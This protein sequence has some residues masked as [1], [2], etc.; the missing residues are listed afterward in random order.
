MSRAL[1]ALPLVLAALAAGC[2]G[3]PSSTSEFE[4]EEQNV[5]DTVEKLQTAGETGD[6]KTICD[7]L[8]ASALREQVQAAGSTCEQELDKAIKDADDF[9]LEVQDVA[10]TGDTATA[11][12]EGRD[13]GAE[14][15]R[16]FEFVREGTDWRATAVG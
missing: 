2:A 9:D 11:R 13:R 12:V 14:R 8:L 1:V 10:I 4:G 5:A 6:A 15:V 7:D 16:T 3:N